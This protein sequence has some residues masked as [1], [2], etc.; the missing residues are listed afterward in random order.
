MTSL[1]SLP[2]SCMHKACSYV[3]TTLPHFQ[4]CVGGIC[5]FMKYRFDNL[6]Q[7]IEIILTQTLTIDPSVQLPSSNGIPGGRSWRGV[8]V[9]KIALWHHK[10][11]PTF[12]KC[13][14]TSYTGPKKQNLWDNVV[15]SVDPTVLQWSLLIFMLFKITLQQT[16]GSEIQP[17]K[18]KH[19]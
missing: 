19:R 9:I 2:D 8:S 11:P 18:I 16:N 13:I 12:S 4:K 1:L 3:Q 17:E 10:T 5:C 6:P 14:L 7:S 15:T